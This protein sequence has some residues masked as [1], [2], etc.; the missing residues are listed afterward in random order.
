DLL[1]GEEIPTHWAGAVRG[2]LT[3]VRAALDD[4][5]LAPE[6]VTAEDGRVRLELPPS[7][8]VDLSL[9]ETAIAEARRHLGEGRTDEALDQARAAESLL[10]SGPFL[11]T[12]DGPWVRRQQERLVALQRQ[13]AAIAVEALCTRGAPGEAAA[14]AAERLAADPFDER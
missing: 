3:K 5:G 4:A 10:R 9:A 12:G 8:T 1:W 13:A 14:R 2:V 6:C 7:W 11:T